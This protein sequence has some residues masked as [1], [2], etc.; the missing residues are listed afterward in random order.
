MLNILVVAMETSKSVS[1]VKYSILLLVCN[2]HFKKLMS[3]T[4][5]PIPLVDSSSYL[6]Y[7]D[8]PDTAHNFLLFSNTNL[9]P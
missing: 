4:S 6:L 9:L 3:I 8:V 2:L 5:V 1:Y 7:S